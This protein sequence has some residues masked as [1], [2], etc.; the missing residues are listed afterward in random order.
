VLAL[1]VTACSGTTQS[2]SPA[3]TS[4]AAAQPSLPPLPEDPLSLLPAD[5]RGIGRADLEQLRA[6][7]HFAIAQR[8]LE[9]YLCIDPRKSPWLLERTDRVAV[10]SF[11]PADPRGIPAFLAVT[12]GRYQAGDAAAAVAQ[13]FASAGLAQPPPQ[14]RGRVTLWAGAGQSVA[15]LGDR[16]LAA[17]S[18]AQVQ[19]LL[20]VA[21]G[22]RQSGLASAAFIASLDAKQWLNTH[23]LSMLAHLDPPIAQRMS[24]SLENFGAEGL[25]EGLAHGSAAIALVLTR[26][27]NAEV[28]LLYP[29]P[30]MATQAASR[31]HALLGQASL[32]IRLMG[33]PTALERMQASADGPVLKLLLRL[34]ADDIEQL[35]DRIEPLIQAA[36]P[37]CGQGAGG[38]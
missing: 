8:W 19:A 1:L 12:F 5:A 33:L 21:D 4:A 37:A 10:A 15:Q 18:S 26:E 2:A 22:K 32:L 35:R 38:G 16:L 25:S 20:D 30:A 3:K 34:S 6:S 27:A 14:T 9:Q 17:G 36:A 29:D 23:T 11:A 24:R 13:L 7:P 28:Q 31:I